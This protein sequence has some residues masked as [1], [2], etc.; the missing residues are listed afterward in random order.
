L[1]AVVYHA[2]WIHGTGNRTHDLYPRLFERF[3]AHIKPFGMR[4]VHLTLEGFPGWGDEN[5]YF[6]GSPENIVL[7]RE[8]CFCQYLA[9]QNEVC[10]FTEVDCTVNRMWPVLKED[11]AMLYRTLD[12]SPMNMAWRLAKRTALPF[13]EELRDAV[14]LEPDKWSG[15]NE[16]FR[17]VWY[18]MGCPK[19]G[20]VDYK[21]VR[22]EMRDYTDYVK[23][24]GKY[25]RYAFTWEQKEALCS[26]R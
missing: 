16:A 24:S 1:K 6:Q 4:L 13:F 12:T 19:V 9:E 18:R 21:G 7:N 15:D 25:S 23:H 11:C 2:D 26:S 10:W 5:H 14:R 17:K 8:E 20:T 3:R 22:I